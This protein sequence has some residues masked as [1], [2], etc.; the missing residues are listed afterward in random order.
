[1]AAVITAVYQT[2]SILSA[3]YERRQDREIESRNRR[4]EA[5]E[6]YLTAFQDYSALW[7]P[8][9]SDSGGTDTPFAYRKGNREEAETEIAQAANEY[10][11]AYRGLF[12]VATDAVLSA[13]TE[14]H[15]FGWLQDTDLTDEAF[16]EEFR[17]RFAAVLIEM[18]KDAFVTTQLPQSTIEQLLPYNLGLAAR[19]KD[20]TF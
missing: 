1:V 12:H 20:D 18:R 10:W 5:Y 2:F 9:T 16:E 14:F 6:R 19:A 15:M 11:R 3:R 8:L 7:D 17:V 13:V 4:R